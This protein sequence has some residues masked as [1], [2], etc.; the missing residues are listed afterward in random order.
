[1]LI[2]AV[3]YWLNW[4]IFR[5]IKNKPI[6]AGYPVVKPLKLDDDEYDDID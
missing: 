1:M 6:S 2:F 5:K 4:L 3:K